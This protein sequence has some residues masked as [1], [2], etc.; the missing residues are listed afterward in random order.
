MISHIGRACG[1]RDKVSIEFSFGKLVCKRRKLKFKFAAELLLKGNPNMAETMGGMSSTILSI[2]D[3]A[4]VQALLDE[5]D[6][7]NRRV[8]AEE[9][10]KV[11]LEQEQEEKQGE[12]G[13]APIPQLNLATSGP[14]TDYES[15]VD[16]EGKSRGRFNHVEKADI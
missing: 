5:E 2:A 12:F 11:E 10:R 16:D 8:D 6:N 13:R 14:A 1:T 3:D 15:K 7:R 9:E 4:E